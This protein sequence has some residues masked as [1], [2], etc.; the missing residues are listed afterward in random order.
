MFP[1]PSTATP[2][3]GRTRWVA[4][5]STTRAGPA[6]AAPQGRVSRS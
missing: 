6:K 5:S 2:H 3:P 1:L 4:V